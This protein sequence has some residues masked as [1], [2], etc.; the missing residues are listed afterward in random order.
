VTSLGTLTD[1]AN[2]PFRTP[3]TGHGQHVAVQLHVDVLGRIDARQVDSHD[4]VVAVTTSHHCGYEPE[5]PPVVEQRPE[6]TEDI[7]DDGERINLGRPEDPFRTGRSPGTG[8]Q[9]R[10]HA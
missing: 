3:L 2:L 5:A 6:G 1:L 7:I 9:R 8:R 4:Q 10:A